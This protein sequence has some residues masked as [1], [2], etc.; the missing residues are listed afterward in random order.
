M[1][2]QDDPREDA[3]PFQMGM[4]ARN[5]MTAALLAK[6]GFGAPDRIFDGGHVVLDAFSDVSNPIALTSG[7][8]TEWEG[9]SGLAVKPYPCVSFL[10]PRA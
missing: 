7:L 3:R 2:W 8:G 5:G 9:V 1:A 6:S 10:P 4:A